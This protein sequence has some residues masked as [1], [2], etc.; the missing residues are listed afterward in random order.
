MNATAVAGC[1]KP[2][3]TPQVHQ[4]WVHVSIV[5]QE[6]IKLPILMVTP[7]ALVKVVGRERVRVQLTAN[8]GLMVILP[9]E[10]YL[11][12]LVDIMDIPSEPI[13][14]LQPK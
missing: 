11:K 4:Q 5:D 2:P 8:N 10:E 14:G 1:P 9:L 13:K 7:S 12:L 3:V 6:T